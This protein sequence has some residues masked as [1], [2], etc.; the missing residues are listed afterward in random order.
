MNM[1]NNEKT[2]FSLKWSSVVINNN[3]ETV[4]FVTWLLW[5][6]SLMDSVSSSILSFSMALRSLANILKRKPV[7][8]I[9]LKHWFALFILQLPSVVNKNALLRNI[10][11]KQ[12]LFNNTHSDGPKIRKARKISKDLE[13]FCKSFPNLVRLITDLLL[14]LL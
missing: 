1:V 2:N 12:R 3:G 8:A 9:H 5:I 6:R 13:I 4:F 10:K 14:H 7:H 11:L